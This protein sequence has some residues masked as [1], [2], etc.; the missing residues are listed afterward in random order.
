MQSNTK[1]SRRLE[2]CQGLNYIN[3]LKSAHSIK[4]WQH[5]TGKTNG[6]YSHRTQ[7][8][9]ALAL[10]AHVRGRAASVQMPF[11]EREWDLNVI[12]T[13]QQCCWASNPTL[14]QPS[15]TGDTWIHIFAPLQD[16][17]HP[18]V[19]VAPLP[20]QPIL[21]V[22]LSCRPKSNVLQESK[23]VISLLQPNSK[24]HCRQC[25]CFAQTSDNQGELCYCLLLTPSFTKLKCL[26]SPTSF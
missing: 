9:I 12:G 19:A 26:V 23:S 1:A 17:I 7:L 11:L 18:A 4:L 24:P 20:P 13:L 25:D 14:L 8:P 22:K 10:P 5:Y 2:S 16:W 21:Q 6:W 3:S 15:A